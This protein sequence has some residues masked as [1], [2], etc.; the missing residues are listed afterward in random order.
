MGIA[1]K[2]GY[3]AEPSDIVRYIGLVRDAI[4][5]TPLSDAPIGH[6]DTWTAWANSSN[7]AVAEACDWVGMDAYPY[8]QSTMSN[9]IES[10]AS[11]FNAALQQTKDATAGKPVW[12]T[13]TGWPVS[14]STQ[15]LGV[16][17]VENAK[18]Y[19]DAVGCP[20]FGKINTWWYTL[21]D[22][23]PV[24]PNPSFGIVGSTLSTTP[25]FDLSCNAV[26]SSSSSAHSSTA[27]SAASSAAT[28]AAHASVTSAAASSAATSFSTVVTGSHAASSGAAVSPSQGVAVA[29]GSSASSGS[30]PASATGTASTSISSSISSPYSISSPSSVSGGA[31][32]AANASAIEAPAGASAPVNGSYGAATATPSSPG[33]SPTAP[34]TIS[35]NGA[36]PLSRS[37]VLAMGAVLAAFAAL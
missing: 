22:A 19:W 37:F 21:Q 23:A 25:L 14:G 12:I 5:G 4:K 17:S 7:S 26:S 34:L 32:P 3:G 36:S 20:N 30:S 2:S 6:V 18:K 15:N 35:A 27:T 10:G 13:E 28:G 33:S 11:L 16:P 24:T 31:G 29:S 8:F 9:S 1:A